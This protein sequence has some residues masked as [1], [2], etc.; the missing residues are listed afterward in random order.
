MIEPAPGAAPIRR[1][2]SP[3]LRTR[4]D[5]GELRVGGAAPARRRAAGVVE[6]VQ[7]MF[8]TSATIRP[9]DRETALRAAPALSRRCPMR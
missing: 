1:A 4:Y 2:V 8:G 5:G 7:P 9:T 6:I 3:L